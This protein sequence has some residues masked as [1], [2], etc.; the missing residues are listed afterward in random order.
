[1]YERSGMKQKC[2]NDGC[3]FGKLPEADDTIE[4]ASRAEEICRREVLE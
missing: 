4:V 2:W 1:M 3:Q